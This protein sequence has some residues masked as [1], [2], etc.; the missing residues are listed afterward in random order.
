MKI[1]IRMEGGIGDHLCAI[2]FL[3]AIKELSPDCEFYGFSDTENNHA[4]KNIIETFWPSLFNKIEVIPEKKQKPYIIHSQFGEENYIA[5]FDNI[6]DYYRNKMINNYD[7]FYDLHIDAL[8]WM[9]YD[10]NWSKY[11]FQFLPLEINIG[12]KNVIKNQIAINLYSDSNQSNL[13]N[14]LYVENLLQKLATKYSLIILATEKNQQFYNNCQ[15]YATLV[16]EDITNVCKIIQ[17]SQLFLTIDSGL[18]F[19]GYSVNTPTINFLSQMTHYGELPI[20]QY[21]RWN[22]FIWS[23]ITLH[24]NVDE[25][26]GLINTCIFYNSNLIPNFNSYNIENILVKRKII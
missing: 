7:K 8:K 19:L 16:I 17:N 2:R 22:P 25:L 26:L 21:I 23:A 10:F 11:F 13:L 6:P 14:K 20:H 15:K 3:P 18:K 12:K 24:Y 4:P 5:A 9:S 1:A